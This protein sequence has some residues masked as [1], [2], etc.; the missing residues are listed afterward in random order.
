VIDAFSIPI[1]ITGNRTVNFYE[2]KNKHFFNLLKI[3]QNQDFKTLNLFFE[4]LLNEII[5]DK[6]ILNELNII[7]KIIILL[8]IRSICISPDI[9]FENKKQFKYAKKIPISKIYKQLENISATDFFNINNELKITFC[10]PKQLYFSSVDELIQSCIDKIYINNEVIELNSQS[11]YDQQKL[12]ESLP[13]TVFVK[14]KEFL[15][16]IENDL[17]SITLIENDENFNI[18]KII[19]SIVKNT[20]FGLLASLYKDN[21]LNFYN[22][23]YIFC[24]KLNISLSEYFNLTPAESTLILS[25]YLKEQ[26]D[27]KKASEQ[28]NIPIGKN[29]DK[30]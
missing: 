2:L 14:S 20:G 15:D 28:K 11:E 7:D 12:L 6:N 29:V 16:K 8:N 22:L 24:N 4:N 26:E 25:F 13:G 18:N 30:Q 19:F 23:I 3:I 27:I 10:L 21:L 5:V 17:N 1:Q 9:E